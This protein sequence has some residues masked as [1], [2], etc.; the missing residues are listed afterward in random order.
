MSVSLDKQ[1]LSQNRMEPIKAERDGLDV[2]ADLPRFAREGTGAVPPDDLERLKW[3]GLSHRNKAPGTFMLRVRV[4][5]GI[6]AAHRLLALADLAERV[7]RERADLTTRQNVQVRW[8][9]VDQA[10]GVLAALYAAGLAAMQTGLDNV[11]NVVGCPLAGL[12]GD[13]L[14][15]A[16]PVV[17]E[18]TRRIVGSRAHA[19][20]PRRFNVSVTG[21]R[22]DGGHALISD[23]GLTPAMQVSGGSPR[24]GFNVAVGGCLRPAPGLGPGPGRLG[25]TRGSRRLP[26]HGGDLPGPRAAGRAAAGAAVARSRGGLVAR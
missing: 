18:I 9:T 23:V 6:L 5:G 4:P 11:R 13:E 20:L 3:Y 26:G 8:I 15:D 19:N 24:L 17:R 2:L 10:P 1:V 21:C 14:L 7:G 22:E 12:D 16:T 25:P